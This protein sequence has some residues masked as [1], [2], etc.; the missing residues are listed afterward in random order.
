[1]HTGQDIE[2]DPG[3]E[4]YQLPEIEPLFVRKAEN[5]IEIEI[6]IGTDAPLDTEK[7]YSDYHEIQSLPEMEPVAVDLCEVHEEGRHLNNSIQHTS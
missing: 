4:D 7:E 6:L 3:N 1:M 5:E 2:S